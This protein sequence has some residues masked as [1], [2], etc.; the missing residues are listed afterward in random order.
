MF[1]IKER[2][3]EKMAKQLG[4]NVEKIE[5]D[6]V[7]IKGKNK[8]IVINKPQ[9]TKIKLGGQETF[10]IIGEVS[11]KT[12]KFTDEDIKIVMEQ[13]KC[14]EEEARKALESEGNIAAAIIKLRN[15]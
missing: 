6:Q 2:Q 4:M 7:V 9:V 10:Q 11:E 14:S 13:T 3:L 15:I 12:S 1:N 5:A 8:D